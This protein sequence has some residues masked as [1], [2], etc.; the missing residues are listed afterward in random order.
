M[1]IKTTGE[2]LRNEVRFSSLFAQKAAE[3]DIKQFERDGKTMVKQ[4]PDGRPIHR[5]SLKALRLQ[6]GQPVGED[7]SVSLSIIDRVDIAAGKQYELTGI[8]WATHYVGN[9]GR[10][11]LSIIAESVKEVLPAAAKFSVSGNHNG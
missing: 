7:K 1:R 2:A 11:A 4:S 9:D 3:Q 10:L 5:T 6:D 8:V